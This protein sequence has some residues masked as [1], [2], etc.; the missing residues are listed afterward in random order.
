MVTHYYQLAGPPEL[1]KS[2]EI[3]IS[4]NFLVGAR[5]YRRENK[6]IIIIVIFVKIDNKKIIKKKHIIF[7]QKIKKE[8]KRN[9][10]IISKYRV[11]SLAW[12]ASM[13]IY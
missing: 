3:C 11:F 10:I 9:W 4:P 8:K 7:R 6:I 2:H 13:Q 5:T 1:E 12:L